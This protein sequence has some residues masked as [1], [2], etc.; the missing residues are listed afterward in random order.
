MPLLPKVRSR[1]LVVAL[2]SVKTSR[3]LLVALGGHVDGA[4]P[5]GAIPVGRA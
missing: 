5:A 1:P 2:A 3:L 4:V